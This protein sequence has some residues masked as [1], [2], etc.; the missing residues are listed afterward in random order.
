MNELENELID[1][2]EDEFEAYVDNL[3]LDEDRGVDPDD[4]AKEA[5]AMIEDT[6]GTDRFDGFNIES[7][8]RDHATGRENEL[9]ERQYDL[10]EAW[11]E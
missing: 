7:Y 5:K 3:D 1:I 2:I 9:I 8:A 11:G 4:F 10:A 6:H